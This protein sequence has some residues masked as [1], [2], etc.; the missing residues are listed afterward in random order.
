MK[1]DDT[2]SNDY[3]LILLRLALGRLFLSFADV[4]FEN[5]CEQRRGVVPEVHAGI[6]LNVLEAAERERLSPAITE[7]ETVK[8]LLP[9]WVYVIDEEVECACFDRQL[10]AER[11]TPEVALKLVRIVFRMSDETVYA[12]N[13]DGQME[14][15]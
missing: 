5:A 15:D 10:A 9:G 8:H 4:P 12:I 11:L 2:R 13:R 1:D 6:V 3:L 14:H 7:E